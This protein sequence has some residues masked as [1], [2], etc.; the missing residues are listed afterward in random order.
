MNETVTLFTTRLGVIP[1]SLKRSESLRMILKG[2]RIPF[3]EVDIG[4]EPEFREYM[5]ELS[6]SKEIPQVF[7][8]EE[9]IGHYKDI[10][11]YNENEILMDQLKKAG[12]RSKDE[13][14]Q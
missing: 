11:A 1:Q 5:E 13:H 6:G 7:V 12:F 8:G 10:E 3:T 4:L 14:D 9:F 2:N